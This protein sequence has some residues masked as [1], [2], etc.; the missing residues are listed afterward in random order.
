MEHIKG[1]G[2]L[3]PF[4]KFGVYCPDNLNVCTDNTDSRYRYMETYIYIEREYIQ[5]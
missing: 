5:F 2:N 4:Y 1:E 3:F